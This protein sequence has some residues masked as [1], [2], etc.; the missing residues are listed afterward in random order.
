MNIVSFD[1]PI[2]NTARLKRLAKIAVL[3]KEE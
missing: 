2:S 1:E 3:D